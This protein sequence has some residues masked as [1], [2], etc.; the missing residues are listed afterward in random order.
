MKRTM[1][2]ALLPVLLIL[3][4]C[5][6]WGTS[7]LRPVDV[8]WACTSRNTQ[9]SPED[10]DLTYVQMVN[11]AAGL[12]RDFAYH[13]TPRLREAVA[14]MREASHALPAK[15]VWDR[16]LQDF[17]QAVVTAERV[18]ENERPWPYGAR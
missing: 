17:V 2:S 5:S 14:R 7:L 12:E 15:P 13:P 4:G 1:H 8:W 10:T 6:E 9:C 16:K 11:T 18:A 3:V